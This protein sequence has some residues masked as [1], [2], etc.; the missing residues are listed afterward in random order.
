MDG[1][2]DLETILAVDGWIGSIA[3]LE[4]TSSTL[5][6]RTV[7]HVLD[8][9]ARIAFATGCRLGA[10]VHEVVGLV[11]ASA[12]DLE[13]GVVQ[14]REELVEETSLAFG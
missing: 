5:G 7:G 1:F 14:Q 3:A 12:H 8:T 2:D 10:D 13:L 6:I 11:I 9:L 4:I